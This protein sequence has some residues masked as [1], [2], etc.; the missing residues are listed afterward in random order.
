MFIFALCLINLKNKDV[1]YLFNLK[2]KKM[3]SQEI[4]RKVIELLEKET[5]DISLDDYIETLEEVL[6]DIQLKLDAAEGDK[7][8]QNEG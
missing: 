7:V 5:S 2:T 1:I 6:T 4:A 8:M 3:S